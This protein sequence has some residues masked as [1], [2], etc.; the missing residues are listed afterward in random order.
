METKSLSLR[1]F[2]K[3][4]KKNSKINLERIYQNDN[5]LI[6]TLKRTKRVTND[7][8]V[9]EFENNLEKVL[10]KIYKEIK[11]LKDPT[12][13]EINTENNKFKSDYNILLTNFQN[14]TS[15]TFYNLINLYKD[16]G[17][18]IPNLH[19]DHNIFKVNP[20]IEENTNKIIH[21]FLTQRSV[22]TKKEI[23]LIKSLVFLN[24]LN[25]FIIKRGNKRKKTEKRSSLDILNINN[26]ETIESLKQNIK[27]IMNLINNISNFEIDDFFNN[28][29]IKFNSRNNF[30]KFKS[31]TKKF[32]IN[33]I[34]SRNNYKDL[35][36]YS[37]T[38]NRDYFR[39][40]RFNT[41]ENPSSL[42]KSYIIENSNLNNDI[43][44]RKSE[45]EIKRKKRILNSGKYIYSK[46]N[47]FKDINNLNKYSKLEISRKLNVFPTNR[48]KYLKSNLNKQNSKT[49]YKNWKKGTQSQPL[50]IRTQTNEKYKNNKI[51]WDKENN[52]FE[53]KNRVFSPF[54][55]K[56]EFFNYTYN[57]LK[58]GNFANIDKDV[59]K[60][61]NEI[62]CK[63]R[64]E[65][66]S[67]LSRYDYKNF[68][69]N[70]REMEAYIRKAEVDK[71]T[72]K[73]YLNNLLSRRVMDSLDNMREK[74]AQI[75]KFNKIIT[76]IG[77]I[78]K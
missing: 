9:T 27:E 7:N 53:R 15:K 72:E 17:Y 75:F 55:N 11:F 60:Y 61:L 71:K 38:S 50:F 47:S 14:N 66:E 26:N 65:T 18:K 39:T 78:S 30:R 42:D 24:K 1:E 45:K 77:N 43:K 8:P 49:M 73:I 58:K 74:E 4:L 52:I 31:S 41:L 48:N 40:Q 29:E 76:T 46:T 34:T 70:L 25:K 13:E 56:D 20:L 57:R 23:L 64:E 16:K 19:T 44:R 36:R 54:L 68:K 62:E 33:N 5:Y 35:F 10:K 2:N 12:I 6:Q 32:E 3:K 21:Y 37:L 51:E 59:K 22:K 63:N 67:T 69:N 28:N